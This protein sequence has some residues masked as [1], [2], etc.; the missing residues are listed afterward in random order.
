MIWLI[1]D[2][3]RKY[4]EV[5][6][7]ANALEDLTYKF[8]GFGMIPFTNIVTGIDVDTLNDSVII[9]G[10]TKVLDLIVADSFDIEGANDVQRDNFRNG[11]FYNAEKFDQ[12]YYTGLNLPLLNANATVCNVADIL[13]TKFDKPAFIKPSNDR[14]SFNAQ[15]VDVRQTLEESIKS[16]MYQIGYETETCVVSFDIANIK[17]ECR[18]FVVNNNVVTGSHYRINDVTIPKVIQKD[19]VIW[20]IADEYALLY[21]PHDVFVMD[22]A[23]TNDGFKIVEYNCLNASGLYLADV[24]KLFISLQNYQN[25]H[26]IVVA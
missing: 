4:D 5:E 26:K 23:E 21:K 22:I 8:I 19:D 6:K 2:A 9:R 20:S 16:S 25:K 11:I 18:F 15:F 13:H 12:A 24:K 10:G 1:Q 7:E 3:H 17:R 14:K